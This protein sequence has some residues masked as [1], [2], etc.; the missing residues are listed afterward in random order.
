[1]YR[2]VVEPADVSLRATM[3]ISFL[4]GHMA[5][6]IRIVLNGERLPQVRQTYGTSLAN[7]FTFF[8]KVA[9]RRK[10]MNTYSYDQV[11]VAYP[12]ANWTGSP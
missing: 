4:I 6:I 12:L 11:L 10:D 7:L 2:R 3:K 1:M 9:V 5:F 8:C